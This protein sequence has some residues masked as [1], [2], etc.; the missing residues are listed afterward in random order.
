MVGVDAG[1]VQIRKTTRLDAAAVSS[2]F[3]GSVH[4]VGLRLHIDVK[5]LG[6]RFPPLGIS[7]APDMGRCH[8]ADSLFGNPAHENPGA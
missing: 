1:R 8:L 7:V 4:Y 5:R 2:F 3:A 6:G